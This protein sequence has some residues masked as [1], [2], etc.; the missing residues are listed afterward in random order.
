MVKRTLVAITLVAFLASTAPA[1]IE[2][3]YWGFDPDTGVPGDGIDKDTGVKVDGNEKV[4]WPYEYKELPVCGMKVLM[5]IGM[6]VEVQDCKDRKLKL[7]QVECGEIG[8][9]GG[10]FPC[11]NGCEKVTLRA[12]FPV[13][14]GTKL[15]KNA[16]GD[17]VIE[18]W[19]GYYKGG[20][21]VPGDGENH[22]V[23]V[24]VKAW[25]AKLWYGTVG[26]EVNVGTLYVTAKPDV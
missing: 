20:D 24:C 12:N 25:K 26:E 17:K 3:H 9:G 6:Y 18:K 21:V 7:K 8:K 1:A 10:D 23:E 2:V 4:Y 5:E 11:Y 15:V 16:E 19:E 13:K 22:E 14:M